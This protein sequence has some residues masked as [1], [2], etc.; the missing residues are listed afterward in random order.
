VSGTAFLMEH[1]P[2]QPGRPTVGAFRRAARAGWLPSLG[3][4]ARMIPRYLR[5]GHHPLQ[6]GSTATAVAYLAR[7]PAAR[8]AGR[9]A[10]RAEGDG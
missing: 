8:A 3:E 10:A 6:D 4:L 7:S 1:D 2:T 5:P 9:G